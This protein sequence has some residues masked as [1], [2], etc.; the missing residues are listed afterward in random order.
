MSTITTNITPV[1]APIKATDVDASNPASIAAFVSSQETYSAN[2]SDNFVVEV[3]AVGDE[4]N[5]VNA[6]IVVMND[7]VTAREDLMNPHYTAIDGV[8]ADIDNVNVVAGNL[9]TTDTIGTVAT[10]IANVNIVGSDISNVNINATNIASINTNATNITDIQN[11]DANAT[12]AADSA[13]IATS[14]AN[15]KGNWSALTGA[16]NIPASV[17]YND[18]VWVLN[19]NLADVTASEP[20]GANSDWT[21]ASVNDADLALKANK[22]NPIFTGSI[23]EQVAVATDVLEPDNGT[24]QTR[25]LIANTTFTDGLADGQFMTLLVTNAGFTITYPTITWFGDETPT[26]GTT[27]KIFFEKIGS[28]LYGTHS[29]GIA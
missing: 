4:I 5:I 16:L 2:I 21:D 22:A 28:T 9:T 26:L 25:T 12:L 15:N 17:N 24:V 29:G 3:N 1:T 11:A 27:D 19:V 20:S 14:S 18:S 8:Y 6:E 7:N 13:S 23:T 10:D